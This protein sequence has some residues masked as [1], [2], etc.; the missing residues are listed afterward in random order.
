MKKRIVAICL[1]LVLALGLCATAA[2]DYYPNGAF[3]SVSKNQYVKYG[4][5]IT[6]KY[7]IN[8]GTGPF[9][10]VPSTSG[11][12][13]WRANF[14][15]KIKKGSSTQKVADY[16]FTGSLNLQTKV[17]TKKVSIIT[18]PGSSFKKYQ[19]LLSM[20]YRRTVG[21]TVYTDIWYRCNQAKTN[22]WV[23]R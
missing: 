12:Y 10:R 9:N 18:N 13:I 23:Y 1:L 19:C 11:G 8:S 7:S 6:W 21:N 5:T 16:D 20:Y 3:N 14:D 2:A 22:F 17:K 15:L 4:K